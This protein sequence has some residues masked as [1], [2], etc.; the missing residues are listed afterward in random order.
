MTG[1]GRLEGRIIIDLE[2]MTESDLHIGTSQGDSTSVSDNPFIKDQ[3]GTPFI[4]GSSVKGVLRAETE[5]L[6]LGYADQEGSGSTSVACNPLDTN[7]GCG[8]CLTCVLYGGGQE[9]KDHR[10]AA[11]IRFRDLYPIDGFHL[12]IRD[13]VSIDPKTRKAMNG[14]F[15]NTEVVNR[16]VSFRGT[17]VIENPS[18][19]GYSDAKL[20]A[21]LS[22]ID[23]FS[24]TNGK[25]GGNVS[26]GYGNVSIRPA[27][28]RKVTPRDY[29]DGTEGE[30]LGENVSESK[31]S[32]KSLVEKRVRG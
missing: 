18:F 23:F 7:G 5:R 6:L 20:G 16:G 13:G 31:D 29:L 10:Q 15:Y 2:I 11:S 4:P 30:D 17:V 22:T 32:W 12:S 24:R 26:R 9:D 8:R 14:R 25:L 1:F 27:S 3:T 19:D 28:I 21:F